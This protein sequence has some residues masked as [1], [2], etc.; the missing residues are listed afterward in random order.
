MPTLEEFQDLYSCIPDKDAFPPSLMQNQ[1]LFMRGLASLNDEQ[2]NA[3]WVFFK[4]LHVNRF[5]AYFTAT[6][7]D[8]G[9]RIG[10]RNPNQSDADLVL[11]RLFFPINNAPY[12][13][14]N[15]RTVG[16][17]AFPKIQNQ[18]IFSPHGLSPVMTKI[19]EALNEIAPMSPKVT[20]FLADENYDHSAIKKLIGDRLPISHPIGGLAAGGSR[21][22]L[23]QMWLDGIVSNQQ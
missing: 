1:T 3:F 9:I 2:R 11:C 13:E 7:D 22:R 5:S 19:S 10:A 18:D 23:R 21:M 6:V 16:K 17:R 15:A 14:I 20:S 4:L 8:M 12:S